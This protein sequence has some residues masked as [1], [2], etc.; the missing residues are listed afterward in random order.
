[1]EPRTKALEDGNLVFWICSRYKRRVAD[2]HRG[3]LLIA[4]L[5]PPVSVLSL[6]PAAPADFRNTST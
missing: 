3:S 6:T 4:V 5:S 2:R 1:M